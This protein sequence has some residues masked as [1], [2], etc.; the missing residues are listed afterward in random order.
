MTAL[1]LLVLP[2]AYLALVWSLQRI[3]LFPPMGD[4]LGEKPH[5]GARF[6][7]AWLGP[8]KSVEAWFLPPVPPGAPTTTVVFTHG[9]AELI[10]MW[11]DPFERLQYWGIGVLLVE[12]PGYG[13]SKGSASE[14]SITDV[15]VA[16]HDFLLEQ[17]EV[18]AKRIVAYGRSVGGG[19]ACALAKHRNV[20]ALI[21]E[22]SFTSVRDIAKYYGLFGPLVRD[23]FDNLAV[24]HEF[25]GPILVLHGDQDEV[26]PFSHAE[27]L[28]DAARDAQ[29]TAMSCGHNDCE[30]PW[31]DVRGFL[32]AHA[33]FPR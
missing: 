30:R 10:D 16:A 20:A 7:R 12:Y 33:L 19:A 11:L 28:R 4:G 26:I 27:R 22:S 5:P 8:H 29:L 31:R 6:R 17:P 21:L 23:P 1:W 32:E 3:A 9:N 14:R 18:D 13:R 15:M 24:V 25:E 2:P